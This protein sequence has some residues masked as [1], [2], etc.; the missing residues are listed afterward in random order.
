MSLPPIPS[1]PPSPPQQKPILA[2]EM[3]QAALRH[4]GRA[5]PGTAPLLSAVRARLAVVL[6]TEGEA[7]LAERY[8]REV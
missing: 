1:L 5:L 8:H 4:G 3:L 7:A 2:R 6:E